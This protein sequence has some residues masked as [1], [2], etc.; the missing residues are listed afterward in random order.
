MQKIKNIQFKKYFK[1]IL[2]A[3]MTAVF[4]V[5]ILPCL[6]RQAEAAGFLP[7]EK[8][9]NKYTDMG[10]PSFENKKGEIEL[11]VESNGDGLDIVQNMIVTVAYYLKYFLGALA[12]FYIVLTGTRI[13]IGSSNEETVT[14][15]KTSLLWITIGLVIIMVAESA[16]VIFS[17]G[18][19]GFVIKPEV[20]SSAAQEK[21]FIVITFIKYLLSGVTLLFLFIAG[22]RMVTA[23]G[24][25]EIITKQ[26]TSMQWGFIGLMTI[27]L[28]EPILKSIYTVSKSGT[29]TKTVQA[30]IETISQIIGVVNFLLTFLGALSV[31]FMIGGGILY[32][33]AM[34][35]EE[36]TGKAK[37]TLIGAVLGIIIAYSAYA[38][39]RTFVGNA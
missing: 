17:T 37:K 19:G 16:T 12:I 14:K 28:I 23:R 30:P 35:N 9:K 36:Q 34:G 25:E 11:G 39:I 13:V 31:L 15:M 2:S 5:I 6:S 7:L 8:V 10:L 29:G 38:F 32:V 27:V 3:V 33:T 24:N 22:M 26:K 21:V 1:L 20:A 4:L 18:G